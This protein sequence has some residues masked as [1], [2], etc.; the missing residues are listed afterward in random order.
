MQHSRE[1]VSKENGA[2]T[3]SWRIAIVA[4]ERIYEFPFRSKEVVLARIPR[5]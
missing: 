5:M 4:A 2:D 3:Q 1:M